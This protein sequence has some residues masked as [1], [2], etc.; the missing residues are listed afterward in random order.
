[1]SKIFE[2]VDATVSQVLAPLMKPPV[3]TVLVVALILYG[4]QVRPTL[5][6]AV[7]GMFQKG[8][9]R[10]LV[11][12]FILW[13]INKNPALSLVSVFAF[14]AGLNAL[15]GKPLFEL[16]QGDYAKTATPPGCLNVTMFDILAAYNNDKDKL[17]EAMVRAGVPPNI[18]VNDINAPLIAA[19]LVGAYEVNISKT[20]GPPLTAFTQ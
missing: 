17:V 5:P 18:T 13:S 4:A 10:A 6:E 19:Y 20:C 3:F 8:W 7:S 12:W 9:F 16:F 2:T 11:L 1:M 15:N 14:L